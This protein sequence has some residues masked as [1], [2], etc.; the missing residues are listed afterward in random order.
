MEHPRGAWIVRRWPRIAAGVALCALAACN[1]AGRER[2]VAEVRTTRVAGLE[3]PWGL[4]SAERFGFAGAGHDGVRGPAHDSSPG[5]L[6][7]TTPEGWTERPP[8]AMRQA[9]WLLSDGA[10][11]YLSVLPGGGGGL[12][13]NV[14]RWRKQMSLPPATPQELA[15]LPRAELLGHQAL[16][17]DLTGTFVGMASGEARAG[18]RL[19]GLLALDEERGGEATFLKLVGPA[20]R[21]ALERERFFALAASLR[22]GTAPAATAPPGSGDQPPSELQRSAGLTWSLPAGWRQD[23]ERAFRVAS[24]RSEEQLD[25]ECWV[26]MLHGDGGGLE[27]NVERWRAQL[28]SPEAPADV[29]ERRTLALLGGEGTLVEI[30]ARAQDAGAMLGAVALLGDRAVFVKLTG[31]AAA[32]AAE[33]ERFLAFCKSLRE[34]AR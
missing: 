17:L 3:H 18:Q 33:R 11:C 30:R 20:E 29:V 14:Q 12:E 6:T 1:Q 19:L 21:V 24:F 27:A 8:S 4:S 26:T 32:V 9:D 13:A 7:W 28:G 2:R 22:R 34:E 5:A 23:A 16:V 10:E 15:A 25:V 31:P